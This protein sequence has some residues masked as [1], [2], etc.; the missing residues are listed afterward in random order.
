MAGVKGRSGRRIASKTTLDRLLSHADTVVLRA[1]NNP[2][3]D[4]MDRARLAVQLTLK[5]IA[6]RT[7]NVTLNLTASDEL[8]QRIMQRMRMSEAAELPPAP[9]LY[10]QVEPEPNEPNEP[11]DTITPSRSTT[12]TEPPS[13]S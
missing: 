12:P 1:I 4:E 9:E 13:A 5:K 10:V 3:N 6:D 11:N 8:M 7:E 2:N